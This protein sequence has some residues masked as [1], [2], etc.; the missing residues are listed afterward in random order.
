MS[1]VYDTNAP[2]RA[3]NISVN[4][5]LIKKAKEYRINLSQTLESEL[6]KIIRKKAEENWLNETQ[7]AAEAYNRRIEKYG[8]F[9]DSIRRF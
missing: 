2:K 5:D 3:T 8:T 4:S 1:Y 9:A 6:E 7:E